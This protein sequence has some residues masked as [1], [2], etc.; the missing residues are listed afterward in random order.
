MNK[1]E[2]LPERDK[3]VSVNYKLVFYM[4]GQRPLEFGYMLFEDGTKIKDKVIGA[5]IDEAVLLKVYEDIDLNIK[6]FPTSTTLILEARW[7]NKN[8]FSLS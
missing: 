7:V 1:E 3:P 4:T 6:D 2:K 5:V 8:F